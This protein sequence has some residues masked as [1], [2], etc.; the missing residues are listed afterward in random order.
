MQGSQ[1]II[2]GLSFIKFPSISL[3][4]SQSDFQP[5][6]PFKGILG[7]AFAVGSSSFPVVLLVKTFY[8][9]EYSVKHIHQT[10]VELLNSVWMVIFILAAAHMEVRGNDKLKLVSLFFIQLFF[11]FSFLESVSIITP[12][13]IFI[14]SVFLSSLCFLR[15]T[16]IAHSALATEINH[17]I[18]FCFSFLECQFSLL[19]SLHSRCLK[20]CFHCS[21]RVSHWL[22]LTSI[23]YKPKVCFHCSFCKKRHW[24]NRTTRKKNDIGGFIV[25]CDSGGNLGCKIMITLNDKLSKCK[26]GCWGLLATT[27][28]K[29]FIDHV[30]HRGSL[31]PRIPGNKDAVLVEYK[32]KGGSIVLYTEVTSFGRGFR[33]VI[34]SELRWLGLDG[35][36]GCCIGLENH[37]PVSSNKKA[38]FLFF[39]FSLFLVPFLSSPCLKIS[40][41]EW[42]DREK[43]QIFRL[44]SIP[45]H[46]TTKITSK[47]DSMDKT[48]P[49]Q[50]KGLYLVTQ[51]EELTEKREF[52][53]I[54]LESSIRGLVPVSCFPRKQVRCFIPYNTLISRILRK[55]YGPNFSILG[56]ESRWITPLLGMKGRYYSLSGL[57]CFLLSEFHV[58]ERSF[59]VTLLRG[60]KAYLGL[61]EDAFPT[62]HDYQILGQPVEVG[63]FQY[64]QLKIM[65]SSLD[66]QS[67]LRAATFSVFPPND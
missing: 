8:S 36:W 3:C 23:G 40:I 50:R 46:N 19:F 4:S 20:V 38:L 33:W 15:F 28:L 13:F 44:D 41:L 32:S 27:G 16:F 48:T 66:H 17:P 2:Y 45:I 49:K 9:F 57:H 60:S 24:V 31:V 55:K 42:L 37:H 11:C 18:V 6:A 56:S 39:Q 65:I 52:V 53:H 29:I 35:I 1:I 47:M 61:Q 7:V 67:S 59:Q 34:S 21:L 30:P 14:S 26:V 62:T 54:G 12:C 22:C 63:S 25:L 58:E 51:D 5:V 43:F 10:Y 64:T